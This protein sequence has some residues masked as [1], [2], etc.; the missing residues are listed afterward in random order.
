MHRQPSFFISVFLFVVLLF[1]LSAF[2]TFF[3]KLA[4][5]ALVLAAAYYLYA[6]A[7]SAR[8]GRNRRPSRRY[9]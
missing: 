2:I 8:S 5:L 7:A 4:F 1:V 3:I 6:R 9:R